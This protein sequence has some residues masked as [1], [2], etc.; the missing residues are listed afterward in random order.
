MKKKKINYHGI[1]NRMTTAR[2]TDQVKVDTV[3]T[4]SCCSYWKGKQRLKRRKETPVFTIFHLSVFVLVCGFSRQFVLYFMLH[5]HSEGTGL[6]CH[7]PIQKAKM[8]FAMMYQTDNCL[9]NLP[10]FMVIT[11][12]FKTKPEAVLQPL[13]KRELKSLC[14]KF[15]PE[16]VSC[17][18]NSY[19]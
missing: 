17:I 15:I 14:R 19:I 11:V 13:L 18:L 9:H 8:W 4:I 12:L 2:K 16:Q 6:T 3:T 7:S 5:S 10:I 1:Y